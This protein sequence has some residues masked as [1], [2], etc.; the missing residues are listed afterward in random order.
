[1]TRGPPRMS[2][3]I[4][5]WI[6]GAA[7]SSRC[8]AA[9]RVS[10]ICRRRGPC[11][12]AREHGF[13]SVNERFTLASYTRR[14]VH[15]GLPVDSIH[16]PNA[17]AL[18][19]AFGAPGV[20]LPPGQ[21]VQAL[22]LALI[23]SDIF[24]LQLPQAVVDVRSDVA[25]TP[26]S[27]ITL[28]VK[29]GGANATLVIYSDAAPPGERA[30]P[31][32]AGRQPI[33]QAVIVARVQAQAAAPAQDRISAKPTLLR[34]APVSPAPAPRPD[35][36]VRVLTPEQ[37]VGEAV[38]VAATRQTGLAPLFADVEHAVQVV[39]ALPAPV[40]IA[41]NDLLSLRVPLDRQISASDV[42]RAFVRSGLLLEARFAGT[43]EVAQT[44]SSARP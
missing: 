34:E 24:R 27:T 23:E 28:A 10:P 26:G 31:N 17:I 3:K 20:P 15:R 19:N 12:P 33:G 30:A 6:S 7:T 40:R 1:M 11:S 25:L 36:P 22:V 37:A 16:L 41:S 38:R 29:S 21:V 5:I 32:I 13:R 42:R 43:T 39:E 44:R 18:P 4:G 9:Q 2:M 35:A 14:T 8:S